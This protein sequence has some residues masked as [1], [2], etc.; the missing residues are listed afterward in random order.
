VPRDFRG[1][2]TRITNANRESRFAFVRPALSAD[3]STRDAFVATLG[4]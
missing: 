3:A 1:I 4:D 2:A